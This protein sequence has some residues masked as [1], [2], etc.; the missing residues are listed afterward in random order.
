MG[1]I[2]DI[3]WAATSSM[4]VSIVFRVVNGLTFEG[5]AWKPA[6]IKS[7]GFLQETGVVYALLVVFGVLE[8]QSESGE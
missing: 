8:N 2:R 5:V 4:H 1:R 6:T 7:P 3:V